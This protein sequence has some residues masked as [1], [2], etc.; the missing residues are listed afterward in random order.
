MLSFSLIISNKYFF[1]FHSAR[2]AKTFHHIL[3]TVKH[4]HSFPSLHF[5]SPLI[6]ISSVCK[7]SSHFMTFVSE[8]DLAVV[9]RRVHPVSLRRGCDTKSAA[10][11]IGNHHILDSGHFRLQPGQFRLEMD[12]FLGLL[13]DDDRSRY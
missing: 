13:A 1:K 10:S 4:N 7:C 11:G 5:Q 12:V 9:R 8:L 2:K 6:F 3:Q